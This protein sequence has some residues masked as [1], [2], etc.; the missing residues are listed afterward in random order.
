MKVFLFISLLFLSACA[1]FSSKNKFSEYYNIDSLLNSQIQH[2]S[3]SETVDKVIYWGDVYEEKELNSSLIN[4]D[5]EL[6]SFRRI[7]INKPSNKDAY[8]V[9]YKD[10][11]IE[12]TKLIEDEG[13]VS[14]KIIFFKENNPKRISSIEVEKNLLYNSLK[15]YSLDFDTSGYI[16]KYSL[17]DKQKTIFKDTLEYMFFG[18]IK[19]N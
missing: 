10:N 3:Q 19:W 6:N 4:W 9:Y 18:E 2:L 7:D 13:V 16:I 1:D 17:V 5:K 11:L 14:L 8:S 12:Y 15:K